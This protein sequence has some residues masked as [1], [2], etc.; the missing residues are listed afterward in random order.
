MK[1]NEVTKL[2]FIKLRQKLVKL[3]LSNKTI[4]ETKTK[5]N[6]LKDM[7]A[8]TNKVELI[9]IFH[10]SSLNVMSGNCGIYGYPC[11]C[12]GATYWYAII[13]FFISSIYLRKLNTKLNNILI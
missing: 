12:E 13:A 4:A 10:E 2:K 6:R 1:N 8:E 11:S 9:H 3:K 5:V 7:T